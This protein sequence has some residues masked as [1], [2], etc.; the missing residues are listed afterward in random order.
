MHAEGKK[1]NRGEKGV[2][3]EKR[4]K[5][6]FAGGVSPPPGTSSRMFKVGGILKILSEG[7]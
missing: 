5:K 4:M 2:E 1:E 7:G 6:L 3:R